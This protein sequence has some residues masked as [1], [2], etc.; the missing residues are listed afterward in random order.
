MKIK[1][2]TISYIF[3]LL[4]SS[5]VYTQTDEITPTITIHA[6]ESSLPSVLSILA[7]RSLATLINY[8]F[9]YLK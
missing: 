9:C 6:V 1:K 3:I 2:Y 8:L 7:N 4:I 5:I